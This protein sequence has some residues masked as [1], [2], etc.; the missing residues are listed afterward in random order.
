MGGCGNER[1]EKPQLNGEGPLAIVL[2][3]ELAVPNYHNPI[4][5]WKKRHMEIINLRDFSKRECMLC[6]QVDT[7]CNNCHRY[8]GVNEIEPFE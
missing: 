6:H 2:G 4:E 5:W 7:S 1:V 3:K 8:V